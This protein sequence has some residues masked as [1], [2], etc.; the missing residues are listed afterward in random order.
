M[1]YLLL[2]EKVEAIQW[3]GIAMII[4]AVILMN[5]PKKKLYGENN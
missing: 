2:H 4:F 1:A 5:L 3:F